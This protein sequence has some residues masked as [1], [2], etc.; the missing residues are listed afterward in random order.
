MRRHAT[1]YSMAN[2][3]RHDL[4]WLQA[5]SDLELPELTL[6]EAEAR[7]CTDYD[8]HYGAPLLR[9]SGILLCRVLVWIRMFGFRSV[10]KTYEGRLTPEDM[11]AT[12]EYARGHPELFERPLRSDPIDD[13]EEFA[14]LQERTS[15]FLEEL[16]ELSRRHGLVVGT[17]YD[18]A[19][20][21]KLPE[22]WRGYWV[23]NRG[24]L[25]HLP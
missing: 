18:G 21:E 2:S 20:I 4:G 17:G 1:K 6:E 9:E 5:P 12:I 22:D 24:R 25:R 15:A 14:E 13:L 10:M 8:V 7:I 16:A 11:S 19:I 3:D 23:V